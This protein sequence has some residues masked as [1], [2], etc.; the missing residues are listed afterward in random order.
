MLAKAANAVVVTANYRL[1][2][3][4][5]LNLPQLRDGGTAGD[6]SGNFALLDNLAALRYIQ[7]QHRGLRRR[8]RQRDADGRSRPAPSTCW[9]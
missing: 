2:V 8:R 7:A 3:L 9:R 5:F 1:G 6:D 4:G